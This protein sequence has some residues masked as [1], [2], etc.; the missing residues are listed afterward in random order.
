MTGQ[1]P[2]PG[3]KYIFYSCSYDDSL[4]KYPSFVLSD[5]VSSVT[6]TRDGQCVLT[7]TL[8]DSIKLMDKDTGEMLN[9]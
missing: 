4:P 3:F 2:T 8:D 6:F 7:S 1:F 9:E 5:P